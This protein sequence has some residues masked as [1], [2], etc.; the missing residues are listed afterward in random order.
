MLTDSS[1]NR[2]PST[3][4]SF[5]QKTRRAKIGSYLQRRFVRGVTLRRSTEMKKKGQGIVLD[6][7]GQEQPADRERARTASKIEPDHMPQQP[8][9]QDDELQP[10]RDKSGF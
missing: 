2:E 6:D 3:R 9:K 10:L 1:N 7:K 4:P 8:V 5:G